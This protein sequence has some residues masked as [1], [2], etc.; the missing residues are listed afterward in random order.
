M[1]ESEKAGGYTKKGKDRR[2]KLMDEA[3]EW[4]KK[5]KKKKGAKG[6]GM[7]KNLYR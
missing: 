3:L 5:D 6:I 2:K 7:S 4:L 1:S